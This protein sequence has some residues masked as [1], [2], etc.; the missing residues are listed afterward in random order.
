MWAGRGSIN[1]SDFGE[2]DLHIVRVA[3]DAPPKFDA[4]HQI[5]IS[6]FERYPIV[7]FTLIRRGCG[8]LGTVSG[9]LAAVA[10]LVI[11]VMEHPVSPWL[12]TTL[13]HSSAAL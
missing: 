3:F 9:T 12:P 11:K 10:D 13:K 4:T 7:A 5:Q 2:V 6:S 1:F 8:S